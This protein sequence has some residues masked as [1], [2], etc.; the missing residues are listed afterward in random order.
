MFALEISSS[1][2]SVTNADR[3]T[4]FPL[5]IVELNPVNK[6]EYELIIDSLPTKF[7]RSSCTKLSTTPIA[8]PPPPPQAVNV[9][10]IAVAKAVFFNQPFLIG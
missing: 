8:P 3:L 1:F 6:L 7:V 10:A 4:K 9:V 5:D 2:G